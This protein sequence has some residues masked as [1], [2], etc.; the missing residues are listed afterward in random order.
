MNSAQHAGLSQ[1]RVTLALATLFLGTFVL[2]TAELGVV[3][4]LN[5][6]ADDTRVSI[7]TAGTLV[8]AYAL[9]LAIGGPILAALTIRVSRRLLLASTLAA[10]LAGTLLA[11]LATD[12]WPFIAAR[13]LTGSLHGLFVGVAFTVAVSIVAP[14]HAGRAMSVVLGGVA[15]SAALGVPLGTLIG[16]ALGWRGAF[17][18]VI[19]LGVV[20]LAATVA[21]IPPVPHTGVA[22]IGTQARHALAP[23]VLAVLGLGFLLFASQYAA[24][25]YIA[26]F[27]EQVTGVSGGLISVFLFAYGAA[28][29]LGVL[30][31]GRFAD[32]AASRTLIVG[33][34]VLVVAA[35]MLYLVGAV[36]IVVAALLIVWGGF[37]LGVVPSLQY[38]VVS[39]A[40]PGRDLAATL[41]AS[42]FNAGIAVGALAGGWA[43]ASYRVSSVF[44]VS[45]T[46]GLVALAVAWATRSLKPPPLPDRPQAPI[47][48][49]PIEQTPILQARSLPIIMKRESHQHRDLSR[50]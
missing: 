5:L 28:T 4:M 36:P 18:T 24:F 47:E 9:G 19:V 20:C 30:A 14:E 45:L 43:V 37:G 22:G 16:Q 42:A 6:I 2:G 33:N 35:G 49:A 29:A 48:Q 39:L 27:L 11:V 8:T 26:P 15:V 25:T 23:R 41:P 50:P 7:S 40:G 32:R 31:G 38:R 44:L 10:Y 12:F 21:F 17:S 13:A 1:T 3:G 34:A 46:I